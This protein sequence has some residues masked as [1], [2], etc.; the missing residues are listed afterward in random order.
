MAG[1]LPRQSAQGAG[2]SNLEHQV[3]WCNRG[4]QTF[5]KFSMIIPIPSVTHFDITNYWGSAGAAAS[6]RRRGLAAG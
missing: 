4:F 5:A 1:E 6:D 3:V 2:G